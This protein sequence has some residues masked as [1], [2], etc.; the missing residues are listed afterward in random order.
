LSFIGHGVSHP[1]QQVRGFG[2]GQSDDIGV[3]A[4]DSGDE[5]RTD[6]LDRITTCL[7]SEEHTSELQSRSVL[8][9]RLLLEQKNKIEKIGIDLALKQIKKSNLNIL[10]LDGTIKKISNEIKKLINE[11]TLIIINKK[12]LKNFDGS[13]FLK[14][15]K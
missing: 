8:V 4:V 14:N 9:C 3:G 1:D 6:A 7:R 11:Q 10:I 15:L 2:Q 12:D 5:R 13:F